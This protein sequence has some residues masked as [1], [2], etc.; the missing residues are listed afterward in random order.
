M[1]TNAHLIKMYTPYISCQQPP[2]DLEATPGLDG[3]SK[4]QQGHCT[5]QLE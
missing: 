3:I 4:E 5:S 1:R 2:E